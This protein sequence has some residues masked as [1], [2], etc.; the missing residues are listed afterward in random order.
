VA[1]S[2]GMAAKLVTA[3]DARQPDLWEDNRCACMT[4]TSLSHL[5][6]YIGT[7]A[8]VLCD[9][10]QIQ[11]CVHWLELDEHKMDTEDYLDIAVKKAA[12]VCAYTSN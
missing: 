10:S 6:M 8:L 3:K 2:I 1:L 4:N 5:G 11:C 9:A 12:Y 7:M